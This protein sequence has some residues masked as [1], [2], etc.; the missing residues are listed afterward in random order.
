MTIEKKLLGTSPSGD[1][2]NVEDVFST[3]VY[4]GNGVSSGSGSTNTITNGIDLDGEGGMV[5][6]K[7]RE[8]V[9]PHLVHDSERP[10]LPADSGFPFLNTDLTSAATDT[11]TFGIDQFN[12]DGF[13]LYGNVNRNN[14]LNHDYAS[15]TFRKAPRF[16]DV[17]TWTGNGTAGREIEH[18]LECDV[19]MLIIKNTSYIYGTNWLVWHRGLPNT[20]YLT[21]NRHDNSTTDSNGSF[22]GNNSSFIAPTSTKFTVGGAQHEVNYSGEKYVAY[23]FAHD[24]NG[25]NN[26]GMIACGSYTGVIWP[27]SSFPSINLGWEP[28]YVLIKSEADS[29]NWQIFDTMRG[30]TTAQTSSI[31]GTDAYLSVDRDAIESTGVYL[32]V[33]ATGFNIIGSQSSVNSGGQNF[34]YM[35]IRAPMM[36]AP[37]AGSDVYETITRG[38]TGAVAT[39][40]GVGFAPDLVINSHRNAD[41]NHP[42]YDRLRGATQALQSDLTSAETTVSGGLTGFDNMD[43][44]VLGNSTLINSSTKTYVDHVFKRAKGFFDV[45][46]YSSNNTAPYVLNHSLGVVPEMIWIKKRDSSAGWFISHQF[47]GSGYEYVHFNNASG[48]NSPNYTAHDLR[49]QPTDTTFTVGDNSTVNW[50]GTYVSYLFA[51]VAGVSK[52]GSYTGNGSS[53]NIACGFSAGARFVMIKRT[54]STGDWYTWDTERGIVTGND[55]HLSLN[56]YTAE[57]TTDDSIDPESAGFTVNQVAATNINVSSA[58]YIFLAIA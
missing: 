5:W 24:P 30:I 12:S 48:Y 46:A 47:T 41:R 9:D 29:T 10:K 26:D 21:L 23:I 28:Q 43:G 55:P 27:P 32:E 8:D 49:A 20:K 54:D 18:A 44:F 42:I 58:T 34:T 40:T 31:G 38:G 16:F 2:P 7:G 15:W 22:F 13:R 3:Y 19:G 51:S 17:V 37:E 45:V 53:Q 1:G 52:V 39:I 50:N 56:N 6:T 4:T 11:N 57:V 36:K 33:N 14:A 25:A 35:A